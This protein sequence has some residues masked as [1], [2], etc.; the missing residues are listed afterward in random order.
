MVTPYYIQNW[1]GGYG[2]V[3]ETIYWPKSLALGSKLKNFDHF[4][5]TA[6]AP[7]QITLN[8]K[9]VTFPLGQDPDSWFVDWMHVYPPTL[10]KGGPV[11]IS[12]HTRYW[13]C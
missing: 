11:W 2:F 7:G 5:R 4:S 9:V 3:C 12:F 13:T 1:R 6:G 10:T 8:G